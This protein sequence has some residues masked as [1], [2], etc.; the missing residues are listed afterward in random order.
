MSLLFAKGRKDHVLSLYSLRD[1]ARWTRKA[2]AQE[3]GAPMAPM[4][5][6]MLLAHLSLSHLAHDPAYLANPSPFFQ[7]MRE[8][9][10]CFDWELGALALARFEDVRYAL[11][12]PAFSASLGRK[13]WPSAP[14]RAPSDLLYAGMGQ[15][16]ILPD[17]AYHL[18]VRAILREALSPAALHR[19]LM[20][21]NIEQIGH[22]LLDRIIA[23]GAGNFDLIRDLAV[24]LSMHALIVLMGL[25]DDQAFLSRFACWM[26]ALAAIS[27]EIDQAPPSR[28]VAR[29]LAEMQAFFPRLLHAKA[30]RPGTLIGALVAAGHTGRLPLEERF[31]A[32]WLLLLAGQRHTMSAVANCLLAL[33]RHPEQLYL[34]RRSPNLIAQAVEE[35]LRY[36]PPVRWVERSVRGDS[37]IAGV[38]L[39]AGQR[40]VL[41]LAA[42]N[43]DIP[44]LDR[45]APHPD[46]FDVRRAPG[47]HLSF[48]YGPHFCLGF[49]LARLQIVTILRLV[50]ERFPELRL[51]DGPARME[52]PAIRAGQWRSLPVV[53]TNPA[54]RPGRSMRQGSH[55]EALFAFPGKE[56]DGH[57]QVQNCP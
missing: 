13:A 1:G 22:A 19:K 4:T 2:S 57:A 17:G 12:S 56:E 39:G 29:R 34:V 10:I 35:G 25:P 55:R 50:L 54:H 31:L 28:R 45:S 18:Y 36:D 3:R 23:R 24:P 42:A 33:L 46:V 53:Y 44:P 6:P 14:A 43:R 49:R 8:R 9:R 7:M 52:C 5:V 21:Q 27:G 51:K 41:G 26:Q 11:T 38:L 30:A 16:G 40:V 37:E 32:C 48:G 20:Q 47:R 15:Q